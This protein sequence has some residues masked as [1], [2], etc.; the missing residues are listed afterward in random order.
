MFVH[1]DSPG[2]VADDI[3]NDLKQFPESK[4]DGANMTPV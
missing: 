3:V 1:A 4:V 2:K